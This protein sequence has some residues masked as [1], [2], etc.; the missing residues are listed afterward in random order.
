MRIAIKWKRYWCLKEIKKFGDLSRWRKPMP[1][2]RYQKTIISL[3]Q[4]KGFIELKYSFRTHS[5]QA[6]LIQQWTIKGCS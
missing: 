2:Y 6:W 3:T 5:V 1:K 4:N